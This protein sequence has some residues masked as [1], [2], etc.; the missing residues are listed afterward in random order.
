MLSGVHHVVIRFADAKTE[1][2]LRTGSTAW[3]GTHR[4]WG[5]FDGSA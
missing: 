4:G 5:Q 3:Q 1:P 2:E